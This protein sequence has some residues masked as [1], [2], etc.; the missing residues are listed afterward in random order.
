MVLLKQI[1]D[2]TVLIYKVKMRCMLKHLSVGFFCLVF[3]PLTCS[4][5]EDF[6]FLLGWECGFFFFLTSQSL[7]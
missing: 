5:D 1:L 6:D 2:L 4:V 3:F 7:N